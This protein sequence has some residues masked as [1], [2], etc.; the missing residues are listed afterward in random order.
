MSVT[1]RSDELR[2]GDAEREAAVSVLG[3][4]YAAG[5]ITHEE[6]DQR[7]SLAYAARTN[8]DLWPLFRDLPAIGAGPSGA[9][10][11]RVRGVS[12]VPA[13]PV[14]PRRGPWPPFIPPLLLVVLALVLLAGLPWP[15]LIIVGWLWFGRISRHWS[16]CYSNGSRRAVRGSWS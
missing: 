12:A 13:A 2:I 4:H 15:V 5:R 1:S 8:A 7:S 9:I 16:R 6:F 14:G 3:D 10:H 11:R